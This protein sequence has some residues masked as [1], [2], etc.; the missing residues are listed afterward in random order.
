[1]FIHITHEEKLLG[2]AKTLIDN[3]NFFENKEVLLMHADNYS[4]VNLSELIK[5]HVNRSEY[6][7]A[8]MLTFNTENPQNAGV[9]IKDEFNILKNFYE[10][11]KNPPS[12]IANAAI[13][14]FDYEF[15]HLLKSQY[16]VSLIKH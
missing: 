14:L 11:V 13:Y 4:S 8:T 10:K 15:I 16:Q 2:T 7:L 6:T 3:R 5:A 1:M 12:N 9:V